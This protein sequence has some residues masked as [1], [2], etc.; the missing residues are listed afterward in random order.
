MARVAK[1]APE[2]QDEILDVAQRLF[3]TRGYDDTPIQAIIDEVG[4]AKGTFYHHFPSKPALL[5]ALVRRIVE[6]SVALVQPIADDPRLPAIAKFNA[7]YAHIGAWK[8]ERKEL[9]IEIHR[10]MHAESNVALTGRL[11]RDSIAAFVPLLGGVVEQGV[12]E[13][14]FD[15]PFPRH[16]ARMVMDLAVPMSRSIGDALLENRATPELFEA[17][18]LDLRAYHHAVDRVL[19]AAPGALKLIDLDVLRVWFEPD[20]TR[21]SP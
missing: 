13:G 9:L 12:R 10:V 3:M 4:I 7:I 17:I 14:V 20:A 2:R 8:A 19:G 21:R 6:Q 5:D 15:T 18:A 11:Q 1:S 16:A